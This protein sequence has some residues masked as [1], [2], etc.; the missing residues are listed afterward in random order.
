[1]EEKRNIYV[2]HPTSGETVNVEVPNDTTLKD[3]I[4]QLIT[5]GFLTPNANGYQPA[6]KDA[7]AGTST[8]LDPN[9]TLVENGVVSNSTLIMTNI[10]PAGAR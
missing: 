2:I 4:D 6:L 9:K 1:M 7:A 8:A 10:T 3:V 5:A